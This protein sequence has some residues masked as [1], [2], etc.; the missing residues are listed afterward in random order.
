MKGIDY[1]KYADKVRQLMKETKTK[2]VST[3]R[4][5]KIIR[6]IKRTIKSYAKHNEHEMSFTFLTDNKCPQD[7]GYIVDYFCN[8]GFET[9]YELLHRL[10]EKGLGWIKIHKITCKW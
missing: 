3:K 7:I 1:M 10:N 5:K 8:E 6:S 2:K 4:E 9:K